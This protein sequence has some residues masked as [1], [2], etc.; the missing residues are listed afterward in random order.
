MAEI[1]G[2]TMEEINRLGWYQ[3]L[4]PD[5][6]I[7]ETARRRMA[8]MR[9]GSDLIGE[10]WEITRKDGTKRFISISTSAV[11][12]QDGTPHVLALMHDLTDRKRAEEER[13]QLEAQMQHVQKL[14][15]LGVLAGGIAHDF[16]NLLMTIL[17]NTELALGEL[18]ER[19][20]ARTYLESVES[21]SN[22]AADLCKQML[23]YAGKGRFIV[24]PIDLNALVQNMIRILTVSVSKKA[25]LRCELA[26]SLPIIDGD[27][28]QLDQ[29]LMNLVTNA[30]DALQG[31]AGSITI[32]T[33]AA[34]FDRNELWGES[35]E[36]VPEESRCVFLEVEDTGCGMSRD[37]RE[38]IFDPFFSTKFTGRGLGLAAVLG[39]VRG[40]RGAIKVTSKPGRGT[41]IRVLLPVAREN[42]KHREESPIDSSDWTGSGTVLIV[43]DEEPVRLV[44][45]EMIRKL[46]FGVLTAQNG[47]L[48]VELYRRHR[49][50]IRCVL[51]DL[52][53]PEMDGEETYRELIALDPGVCVLLSS[54]YE[55]EQVLER[56]DAGSP[57]GFIQKPYRFDSL[58]NRLRSVLT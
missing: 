10:E 15:S 5:K 43:D 45:S 46:G 50:E 2:Y 29:V 19:S 41:L 58:R 34:L 37:V 30:S 3:Q 14:E 52:T 6:D 55:E 24:E 11:V 16:N 36:E 17:G 18:P 8:E 51:L 28:A 13:Q 57:L 35:L 54:G 4:Y 53:M 23:A 31:K 49:G 44:C 47:R 33:G 39:I 27:A 20:P 48:A 40:H 25:Q 26:D 42:E 21:A 1:T 22:R 56:F 38:R 7:Q 12:S 9:D 32:R